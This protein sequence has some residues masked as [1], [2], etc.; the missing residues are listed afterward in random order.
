MV[1]RLKW[2]VDKNI[3]K[4][5]LN[6]VFLRSEE[7][8]KLIEEYGHNLKISGVKKLSKNFNNSI[9]HKIGIFESSWTWN[10]SLYSWI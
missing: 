8:K 10:N 2:E 4:Y 5:V 9:N 7:I 6:T 3:N 1:T